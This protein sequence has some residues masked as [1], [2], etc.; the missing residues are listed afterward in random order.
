MEE[1]FGIKAEVPGAKPTNPTKAEP[2]PKDPEPPAETPP[3]EGPSDDDP[4][5]DEPDPER[6]DIVPSPGEEE[7]A[8]QEGTFIPQTIPELAKWF[9]T[10]LFVSPMIKEAIR[11]LFPDGKGT[12]SLAKLIAYILVY[13][14]RIK[15]DIQENR[16]HQEIVK[17][18]MGIPKNK[19]ANFF[20]DLKR[21]EKPIHDFFI[22]LANTSEQNPDT[23]TTQGEKVTGGDK[24]TT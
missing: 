9:R 2:L 14:A 16:N 6:G 11:K 23:K 17:R 15:G 7:E 10:K 1:I 20:T 22:K 21:R 3:G 4:P 13:K 5:G 8:P 19:I 24:R 18:F 12:E